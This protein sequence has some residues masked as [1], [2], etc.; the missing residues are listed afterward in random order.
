MELISQGLEWL[1]MNPLARV[2][3]GLIFILVFGGVYFRFTSGSGRI[4]F[5]AICAIAI[6]LFIV[7]PLLN[8]IALFLILVG[9]LFTRSIRIPGE[10][11]YTPAIVRM[12]GGGIKRGLSPAEGAVLLGIPFHISLTVAILGMLQ[13]GMLKQLDDIPLKVELAEEL[14]TRKNAVS[15]EARR[16]AR[17]MA[18]QELKIAIQPYED[19]LIEFFEDQSEG[20][21]LDFNFGIV[22]RPFVRSVV[23]RLGGYSLEE[24]RQYYRLIIQRAPL[25]ARSDG[26]LTHDKERVFDRNFGWILL[27]ED[28]QQIFDDEHFSYLPGWLR[29]SGDRALAG[30]AT[31]AEWV[32]R[33]IQSMK[34]SIPPGSFDFERALETNTVTGKLLDDIVKATYFG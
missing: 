16:D 25:E 13:K 18:A 24:T 1:S 34:A 22:L 21:I 29:E 27:H 8:I 2:I 15:I 17:R 30:G 26:E 4:I 28:M 32:G 9:A 23:T 7:S 19:L 10:V 20:S 5:L 14:R 3:L 6:S 31:F 12:E 33:L 11:G